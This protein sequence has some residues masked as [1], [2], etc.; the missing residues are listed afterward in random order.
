MKSFQLLVMKRSIFFLLSSRLRRALSFLT[1]VRTFIKICKIICKL[2]NRNV[3]ALQNLEEME[4][5]Q[6]KHTIVT[7]YSYN[8]FLNGRPRISSG[9]PRKKQLSLM[10]NKLQSS[11]L[12]PIPRQWYPWV[13]TFV[14]CSY[15]MCCGINKK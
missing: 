6:Q 12:L 15:N 4:N 10:K 7:W 8:H 2:K 9:L 1:L 13:E 14:D 5:G 3:W 11:S